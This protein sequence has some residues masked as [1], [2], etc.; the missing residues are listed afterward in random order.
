MFLGAVFARC[1]S[2][3]F[4]ILT[5][6]LSSFSALSLP[7]LPLTAIFQVFCALLWLLDEYWT[8]TLFTLFSVVMYEATTVFQ[9]T[10]TQKMLGG[11]APTAS[12]IY[13]FRYV[14]GCCECIAMGSC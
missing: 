1:N 10:R 7:P 2:F 14:R 6:S 3:F 9:R 11:M 4:I 12:P 5:L 8:Y 13:V